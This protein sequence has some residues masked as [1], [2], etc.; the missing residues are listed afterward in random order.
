ARRVSQSMG[1]ARNGKSAPLRFFQSG[2]AL[3]HENGAIQTNHPLLP[4]LKMRATLH[5]EYSEHPFHS[6]SIYPTVSF[7]IRKPRTSFKQPPQVRLSH[8]CIPNFEHRKVDT[9]SQHDPVGI[10]RTHLPLRGTHTILW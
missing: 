1:P 6:H 4:V 3:S 10:A 2:P 8:A 9:R 5:V 7:P